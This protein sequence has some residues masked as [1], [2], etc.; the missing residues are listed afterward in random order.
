MNSNEPPPHIHGPHCNHGHA[1][2]AKAE[3]ARR[4]DRPGRNDPCWCGSEKKYKK[5][6]FASDEASAR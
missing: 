6:H 4:T 3:P 2:S 1:H 5:C